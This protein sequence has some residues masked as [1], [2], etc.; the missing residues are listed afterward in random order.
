MK[1]GPVS[2]AA[3][4]GV[5]WRGEISGAPFG[6][7]RVRDGL[8]C[9]VAGAASRTAEV[10][11]GKECRVAALSAIEAS[12]VDADDRVPGEATV[13]IEDATEGPAANDLFDPT[14]ARVEEDRLPDA[15][16]LERFADVVVAAAI[17]QIG[18]VG[19]RLL[20]IRTGTG[21]HA[22]GPSELSIAEDLV[23][24]LML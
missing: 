21:V 4:S 16:E 19:T 23:R 11:R 13:K 1:R 2:C 18:V 22:F 12:S 9:T 24:E 3:E 10:G 17:V 14:V 5:C 15:I 6:K 7:V 20:E 8:K